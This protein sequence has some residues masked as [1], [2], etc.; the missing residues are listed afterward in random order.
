[1]KG[2]LIIDIQNDYF[3]GGANPLSGSEEACRNAKKVL[4]FFRMQKHP[5]VHI[6]HIT[7]SSNFFIKGTIGAEIHKDLLPLESE[8]LIIKHFP[9]AFRETDLQEYLESK[10]IE[11]LVVCGMMTHMC[12]DTTV[13][14]SKDKG[15]EIE[16]I[17]DACATKDLSWHDTIIPA[18]HVHSAFLA[19]LKGSFAKVLNTEQ[20]IQEQKE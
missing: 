10:G 18:E 15:F 7:K 3:E 19:A 8:K 20:F 2:L 13:R 6:Q 12:I 4:G 11:N 9:N 1:M 17:H 14:A 5:V 16:L